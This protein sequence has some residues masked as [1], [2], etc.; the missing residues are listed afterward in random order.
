MADLYDDAPEG[1]PGPSKSD[2]SE[3][4]ATAL[5]PKDFFGD[6]TLEPGTR[7]EVEVS[8][9]LDDQVQVTKVPESEYKGEEPDDMPA[10]SESEMDAMMS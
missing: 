4:A 7:C 8:R 6:K 9:V 1:N 5:L 2:K 10:P 3:G